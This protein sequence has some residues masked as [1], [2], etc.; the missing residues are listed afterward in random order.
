MRWIGANSYR[1]SH[2]PY[3]E[4]MMRLA[5]KL[6]FLI[7]DEVPAV[8][9]GFWSN[10]FEELQ[11]LLDNHKKAIKEL[12]KRDKNHPSVISWSITNEPNLWGEEFYQN[13]ASKQYFKAVYDFTK[14]LDT[15]RP[16]M[17]IS[18]AAHKEN[19]VVLESCDIMSKAYMLLQLRCLRKNSKQPLFLNIWKLWRKRSLYLDHTFG[20]LPI[21]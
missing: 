3:D 9:L 16:I 6:G 14:S 4:E 10:E 2:Y 13:N 1:T 18:M 21:L 12:Y 20:I 11:P 17:S 15:T 5:D 7:I 19:D 8:S